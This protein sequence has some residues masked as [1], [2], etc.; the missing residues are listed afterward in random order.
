MS[1][2]SLKEKLKKKRDELA[3]KSEGQ[4]NIMFIKEG[5][6]RIRI[7]PIQ[8]D[9]NGEDQDFSWEISQFYLGPDIKGVISPSTLG[10]DCPILEKQKE[11]AKSSDPDDKDIAKSLS[12]RTRHLIPILLYKDELGK[13][14]DPESYCK[15]LLLTNSLQSQIYDFYLDP[16]WGDLTDPVEGYDIKITRKGSGKTDTEYTVMPMKNSVLPK[17]FSKPINLKEL[18]KKVVPTYEEAEEK[19]YQYLGESKAEPEE[20]EDQPRRPKKKKVKK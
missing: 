14:P 18:I 10:E 19:L 16:D 5:T 9:E 7:L 2:T 11:L 20:E 15:L 1:K 6:I 4:G 17:E 8:P 13:K 12:P 3:K